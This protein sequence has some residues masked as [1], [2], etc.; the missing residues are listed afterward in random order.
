MKIILTQPFSIKIVVRLIDTDSQMF[1]NIL[2]ILH[3]VAA[4]LKRQGSIFQNGFLG[5][6]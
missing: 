6:G 2:T 3:T 5:G 4:Q 1:S